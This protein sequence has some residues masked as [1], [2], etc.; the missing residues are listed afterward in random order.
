MDI[1]YLIRK[2]KTYSGKMKATTTN[3]AGVIGSLYVGK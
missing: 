3:G 1:E 2:Q